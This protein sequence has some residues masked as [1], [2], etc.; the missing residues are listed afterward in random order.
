MKRTAIVA[1]AGLLACASEQPR[2]GEAEPLTA[3]GKVVGS[4]QQVGTKEKEFLVDRNQDGKPE[5]R[6]RETG[7]VITLM[8]RFDPATGA[9]RT[10]II[11]FQGKMNRVE[12]YNPDGS[13]RGVVNYTDQQKARSV[14]LPQRGK[15]VEF[16]S[17]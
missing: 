8:E 5:Y 10:K 14:E 12:V 11:Y 17:D 15:L 13:L 7:G 16:L 1:C 3:D 6:W 2:K 4:V 9:L